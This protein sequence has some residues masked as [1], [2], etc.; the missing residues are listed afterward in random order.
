MT[1]EIPQNL[2]TFIAKNL[3]RSNLEISFDS[4]TGKVLEIGERT[5][6]S[7][8]GASIRRKAHIQKI[9]LKLDEEQ[10]ICIEIDRHFQ[11]RIG[12]RVTVLLA[13]GQN[14]N[15]SYYIAIYNHTINQLFTISTAVQLLNSIYY[16]KG[17]KGSV[18]FLIYLLIYPLGVI[19][20]PFLL[21]FILYSIF[22]YTLNWV[23]LS[24]LFGLFLVFFF[25][26]LFSTID[27]LLRGNAGKKLNSHIKK[28][29]AIL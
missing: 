10:E 24:A 3:F 16:R 19:I 14:P 7:V 13:N 4:Q 28:I 17:W 1:F 12:H 29:L 20:L 9:W 26:F 8:A 15:E 18:M 2:S 23:A 6:T 5:E 25:P 27:I 11:A 22:S 21:C